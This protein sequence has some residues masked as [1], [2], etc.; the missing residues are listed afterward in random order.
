MIAYTISVLFLPVLRVRVRWTRAGRDEGRPNYAC[1]MRRAPRPPAGS[2]MPGV[3]TPTAGDARTYVG[4]RVDGYLYEAQT[5][6]GIERWV[7]FWLAGQTLLQT[8]LLIFFYAVMFSSSRRRYYTDA[9]RS[10]ILGIS[11]R[12]RTWRILDH[13]VDRPGRGSG[14]AL[15]ERIQPQLL[16]AADRAQITIVSRAASGALAEHYQHAVPGLT[17]VRR[18]FPRGV[19]LRREPYGR[20]HP[21]S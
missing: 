11:V 21:L 14:Q 3:G 1:F 10:A 16:A 15:R 2:D 8:P 5:A 6:R 9:D 19:L 7:A 17:G 12:G 20:D 13:A 18:A 4:W